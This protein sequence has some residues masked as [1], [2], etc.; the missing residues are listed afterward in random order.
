M[1]LQSK[2]QEQDGNLCPEIGGKIGKVTVTLTDSPSLLRSLQVM[3]VLLRP[4]ML[5]PLT[6]LLARRILVPNFAKKN[7]P[8]LGPENHNYN[9]KYWVLEV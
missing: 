9:Y 3:V 4:T 6:G 7:D 1:Q 5:L 8:L 2:G